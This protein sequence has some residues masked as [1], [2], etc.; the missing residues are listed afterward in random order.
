MRCVLLKLAALWCIRPALCLQTR[1]KPWLRMLSLS[2]THTSAFNAWN[3]HCSAWK[4]TSPVRECS[5]SPLTGSANEGF[6]RY[7]TCSEISAQCTF[8]NS[9]GHASYNI[10]SSVCCLNV[11]FC[12]YIIKDFWRTW[13]FCIWNMA[14]IR[15]STNNAIANPIHCLCRSNAHTNADW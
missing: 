9:K 10:H 2:Q 1:T 3:S 13:D 12:F 14:T 6:S 15:S 4:S 11:M 5:F 8:A 7:P